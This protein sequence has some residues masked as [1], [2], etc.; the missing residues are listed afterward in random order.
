MIDLD[1]LEAKARAASVDI[2]PT[3]DTK[4][5]A[6]AFLARDAAHAKLSNVAGGWAPLVLALIERVRKAEAI[7]RDLAALKIEGTDMGARC[8]GVCG[9]PVG[10][11]GG[12]MPGC[13]IRRAVELKLG[14]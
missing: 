4:A 1:E 7:V 9:A 10:W 14:L 8:C 6:D 5:F 3:A 11:S 13:L 2:A 12:H